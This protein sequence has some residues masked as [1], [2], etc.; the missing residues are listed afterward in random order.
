MRK[1]ENVKYLE[2]TKEIIY[3]QPDAELEKL[4]N[5][6][7]YSNFWVEDASFF[8]ML[9]AVKGF[10]NMFHK[11]Y[12]NFKKDMTVLDELKE[13][14]FD[15]LIFELL[16]PTAYPIGDYI[17]VKAMLPTLSM[18]HHTIWSRYIGEPSSPS[19]LPSMISPFGNDMLFKERLISTVADLTFTYIV[20][21]APMYSYSD[22]Q[23]KIDIEKESVRAP[24]VF[25]NANPYMDFPRPMLTK[26]ILIGGIS[27]NAT[28][29]RQEK[30]EKEYNQLLGKREKNVLISFGSFI[31][32]KDMPDS[33]KNTIIRVMES[34]PDVTFI[35]KYESDDVGFAKNLKNLHFSKWVPQTALLAD[36]RLSAF[37]THAGLGSVNELSYMGKPAILIPIFADQ[38][39]NAKMLSRHNGSILLNKRDLGNF[40]MLRDAVKTILED[41][42]YRKHAEIL[43]R[44]LEEQPISPHE[45]LV[46]HAEFGAKFGE[47][48]SLDPY[49]RQ[50]SF[51]TFYLIDIILF[52][53]FI[54]LAFVFTLF[55]LFKFIFKTVWKAKVKVQ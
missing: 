44:Q 15:A 1:Y 47:L 53:I 16:C 41:K 43:G 29:M 35:W 17:G 52:F 11:V 42:S 37:I 25:L 18:T 23:R 55:L 28:Q 27:I 39:R 46:K 38:V 20:D 31:Y 30:L 4:G 12:E 10:M 36:S 14:K 3:I 32:S 50:M 33:Y 49:S 48:P 5:A 9:P 54:I 40:E 7:S 26:S 21:E 6:H 45:L 51:F 24:F 8:G 22:P 19:S 13:R 2:S 34:F